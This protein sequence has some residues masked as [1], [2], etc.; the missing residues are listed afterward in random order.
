MLERLSRTTDLRVAVP[1][2]AVVHRAFAVTGLGK[3]VPVFPGVRE[4]LG[5]D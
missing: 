3:V 5:E 2:T 4:A 1:P